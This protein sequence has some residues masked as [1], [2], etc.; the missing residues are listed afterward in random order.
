MHDLLV[1]RYLSCVLY[2]ICR[3]YEY[4][5]LLVIQRLARPLPEYQNNL[6]L[7]RFLLAPLLLKMNYKVVALFLLL[8]LYAGAA[9]GQASPV[10]PAGHSPPLCCG[11]WSLPTISS[12]GGSLQAVPS[13]GDIAR[14][15]GSAMRLVQSGPPQQPVHYL[16]LS[17]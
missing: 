17:F 2:L 4:H 13:C 3:G 16:Y 6:N 1:V 5:L 14:R 9:E 7:Q 10:V 12:H 11:R 8:A 15:I